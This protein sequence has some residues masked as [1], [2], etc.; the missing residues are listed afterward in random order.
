MAIYGHT[1]G[2]KG[3]TFKLCVLTRWDFNFFIRSSP[4]R[5]GLT[6]TRGLFS[7]GSRA[8]CASD[9]SA[10]YKRGGACNT[11]ELGHLSSLCVASPDNRY[12][13]NSPHGLTFT[14]WGCYGSCLWHKPTELAHSFF[15]L[16]L[17]LFLSLW[18]FQLYFIPQ[19]LPTTV[20]FLSLF[21]RFYLCLI[22]PFNY[23]SLYESLPQL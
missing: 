12:L 20:H 18:P 4:L 17:Y 2:F 22:G 15:I 5:S 23:M 13:N 19:I 8:I 7:P 9:F 10:R 11:D 6:D 16:L 14:W 1:P 3:R 21:F